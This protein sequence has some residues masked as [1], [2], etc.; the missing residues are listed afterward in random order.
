MLMMSQLL[1]LAKPF[2]CSSSALLSSSESRFRIFGILPPQLPPSCPTALN[3][4]NQ[5][6]QILV[7]REII[8]RPG[9]TRPGPVK[10][11]V[12]ITDPVCCRAQSYQVR[13]PADLK[14]IDC[15]IRLVRQASEWGKKYQFWSCSDVDILPRD[16]KFLQTC[17]GRGQAHNG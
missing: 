7:W 15:S 11:L 9:Q 5:I 10:Q 12:V 16:D 13:L 4:T 17:S 2:T 14:C 1:L 3:I 8:V 6:Q